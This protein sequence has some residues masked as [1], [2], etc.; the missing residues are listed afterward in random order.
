MYL[1]NSNKVVCMPEVFYYYR[2]NPNG[3]SKGAH[4]RHLLD[5]AIVTAK[6][7]ED[8]IKKGLKDNSFLLL[9]QKKFARE[10]FH[11]VKY[12]EKGVFYLRSMDRKLYNFVLSR[13]DLKRMLLMRLYKFM[14]FFELK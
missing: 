5:I 14:K 6:L 12:S 11:C 2:V 13:L 9:L 4:K 3:L 10:I 8:L 7:H 1:Y